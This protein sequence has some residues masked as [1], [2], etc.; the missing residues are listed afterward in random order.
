MPSCIVFFLSFSRERDR[1]RERERGR[2]RSVPRDDRVRRDR[3]RR[4]ERDHRDRRERHERDNRCA[5]RRLKM[6]SAIFEQLISVHRLC[7]DEGT[8]TA[9]GGI[10]SGASCY[11]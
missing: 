2:E 1:D 5:P 10:A 9:N 3:D 7:A 8:M 11:Q 4:D 6:D